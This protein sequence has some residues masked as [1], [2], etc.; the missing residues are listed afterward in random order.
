MKSRVAGCEER[1]V[2]KQAG[3]GSEKN[4]RR[5]SVKLVEDKD[6]KTDRRIGK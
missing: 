6:D 4:V 1:V 3:C 2:K 5:Y